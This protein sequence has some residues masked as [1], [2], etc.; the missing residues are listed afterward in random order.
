MLVRN[1]IVV[2]VA[3]TFAMSCVGSRTST[4]SAIKVSADGSNAAEP[5]VAALPNG[6]TLVVWVEHG[7]KTADVLARTFDRSGH[8]KG[9]TVRVNNDAG[10]AKAWRG[11]PPTVAVT[12][13]ATVYVGW[14]ASIPNEQGTTLYVSTSRDGG[15]SFEQAIKVNDD[16][17]PASHGMHSLAADDSGHVYV[18]WLDER[19]LSAHREPEMHHDSMSQAEPNAE[20]YFSESSDGGRTFS[21]NRKVAENACPCCK[22]ALAL[23]GDQ[24]VIGWRQVLPGGFR[25]ISIV[26]SPDGGATFAAPVVVADDKWKID[27]CPVSG[28]SLDLNDDALEVA[29]YAG[30]EA[31]PHGVYWTHTHDLNTPKF[32]EPMLVSETGATGTPLLGGGR[33]VWSDGDKLRSAMIAEHKAGEISDIGEGKLAALA[34]NSNEAFVSYVRGSGNE[35]AVWLS[36]LPLTGR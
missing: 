14:T 35:T 18:A 5:A 22:T 32:S 30:G 25:H 15:K 29:W 23:K 33:V 8:A 6:D 36:I 34:E 9:D 27:A 3:C 17:E 20:L 10:A 2:C 12:P 7:E 28:P 1:F 26:S 13:D 4:S 11:D 31:G 21:A 16:A 24:L 19:Y